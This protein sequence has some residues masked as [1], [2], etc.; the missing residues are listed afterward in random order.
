[1]KH[2]I[3]KI[4]DNIIPL[5]K[6]AIESIE[7]EGFELVRVTC[8]TSQEIIHNCKDASALIVCGEKI[9]KEIIEKLSKLKVIARCGVGVDKV[10]LSAAK[11]RGIQVTN[12]P[13]ANFEEVA[14]HTL[15]MVLALTRKLFYFNSS[16]RRG[17]WEKEVASI[18][19]RRPCEQVLGII[20]GGRIGLRVVEMASAIGF[21]V[22]VHTLEILD[23][24]KLNSMGARSA[25]FEDII[26]Q[27]DIISLHIPLTTTTRGII[28]E[29]VMDRMKRGSYLVNVSRGGLVDESALLKKLDS[30]HL[31]GAALDVFESEPLSA[32][33]GLI[34]NDKLILTP[35]IAYLSEDSNLEV[36]RK[37][38]ECVICALK[39]M[40]PKYAVV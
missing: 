32:K 4:D 28:S 12:V 31:T 8:Q 16:I 6:S 33:S 34:G 24:E 37:A 11:E 39:G 27:S 36:S 20:G 19:L 5:D 9:S 21:K 10:D 14:T 35:H 30:G 18:P 29:S 25:T 1:M 22:L 40:R 13:D 3:Y 23:Q 2:K 26:E 17:M 7:R 15:A 38:V